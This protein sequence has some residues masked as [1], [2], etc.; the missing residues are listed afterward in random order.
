MTSVV[1][2]WLKTGGVALVLAAGVSH[3]SCAQGSYND[4]NPDPGENLAEQ[5]ASDREREREMRQKTCGDGKVRCSGECV[6]VQVDAFHCGGCGQ[7]CAP[8]SSC[9]RGTCVPG[10]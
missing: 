7:V 4:L 3:L 6:D 8:P 5:H 9:D 10:G 1:G 2:R